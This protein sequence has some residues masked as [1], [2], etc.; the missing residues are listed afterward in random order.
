MGVL[1]WLELLK[2]TTH[3]LALPQIHELK[4]RGRMIEYEVLVQLLT[5]ASKLAN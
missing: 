2:Q 3:Q 5:L 4:S 1:G